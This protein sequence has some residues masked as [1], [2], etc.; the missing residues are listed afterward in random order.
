MP[1]ARSR[2]RSY[3]AYRRQEGAFAWIGPARTRAGTSCSIPRL[4]AC[5]TADG[6]VVPKLVRQLLLGDTEI[7]R[8][9]TVRAGKTLGVINNGDLTPISDWIARGHTSPRSPG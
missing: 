1:L 9:D 2:L 8:A 7:K 3:R 4:P 5:S 6:L